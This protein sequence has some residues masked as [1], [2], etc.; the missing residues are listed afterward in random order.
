MVD[1]VSYHGEFPG[2]MT[3]PETV[4]ELFRLTGMLFNMYVRIRRTVD[5][6]SVLKFLCKSD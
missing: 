1:L 6:A 3:C 2:F 5:V 4:V